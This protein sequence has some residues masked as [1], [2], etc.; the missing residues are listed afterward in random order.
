MNAQEPLDVPWFPYSMLTFYEKSS[1]WIRYAKRVWPTQD[2]IYE[3]ISYGLAEAPKSPYS[4]PTVQ[5][6]QETQ[7]AFKFHFGP[8]SMSLIS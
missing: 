2:L 5:Y 1:G 6:C 7:V 3:R 8:I 4:T